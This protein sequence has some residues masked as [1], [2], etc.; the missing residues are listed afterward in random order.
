M[1][2]KRYSAEEIIQHVRTVELEEGRGSTLEEASKKS[3]SYRK[4]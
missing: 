1:P 2:R 3:V 4:L